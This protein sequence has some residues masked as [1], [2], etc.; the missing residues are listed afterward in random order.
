MKISAVDTFLMRAEG[1]A[2]MHLPGTDDSA[3]TGLSTAGF[4]HWLFVRLTT[5]CGLT[6]VGEASGWPLA[7][8][9]AIKDLT[10][11]LV[12]KN[13]LAIPEVLNHLKVAIMPHGLMGTFSGGIMAA[14]DMALWD[15][16]GKAEDAP[17][18]QLLG[19][20]SRDRVP[21]YCH[22][23]TAQAA[24]RAKDMGYG[25][26]K[27]SGTKNIVA[28]AKEIKQAVGTDTDVMADLHGVPWLNTEDSI[29]VCRKLDSLGLRFIEEPVAPENRVGLKAVKSSV[30]TPIAAGERLG[31]LH[32]FQDL[33]RSGCVDIV[34]PD[35][36]R[37]GGLSA[38]LEMAALAEDHGLTIAP[39][40]G[41]LGPVAEYAAVHLLASIP[42]CL[43][44]E[45]FA[46]DWQGR[47]SIISTPL[48]FDSGAFVVP[49]RPGLG[50]DICP[51]EISTHPPG[52]NIRVCTQAVPYET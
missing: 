10:P 28:R 22:A 1:P 35:T 45:R 29:S 31:A 11:T 40:S 27:L 43:Y 37:A 48:V 24:L 18:W 4:R 46:D 5:S 52:S 36:G 12:G 21:L 6:G 34:Q 7:Q 20:K 14:I 16:R 41:S 51:E 25:G 32:D 19:E 23:G 17:V 15:I 49:D 3:A 50:V 30:S 9:A 44:L 38:M 47:D 8:A 33:I 26:V 42:N 2:G 39:H 13:P